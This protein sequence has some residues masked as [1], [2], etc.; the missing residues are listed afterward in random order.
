MSS[1]RSTLEEENLVL[2][3][4]L[5]ALTELLEA[6]ERTFTEQNH[7]RLA[8]IEELKQ[9]AESER[10]LHEQVSRIQRAL[11]EEL[12]TPIIP[13]SEH[14]LVMPLIGSV[15]SLRAQRI[16]EVLLQGITE[17]RARKVILDVT[18]LPRLDAENAKLLVRAAR[19]VRL[20]GAEVIITGIGPELAR[21]LVELHIDFGTLVTRS[22]LRAGIEYA[23][24][25]SATDDPN[26]SR[27]TGRF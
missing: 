21:S 19:A 9:R 18:G 2:K 13:L 1:T 3:A 6:Q 26:P 14:V 20:L 7:Q 8:A 23:L 11:L 22:E 16:L 24:Q 15:D 17:K 4:Q 12:S 27:P 10:Q 5:A 25:H